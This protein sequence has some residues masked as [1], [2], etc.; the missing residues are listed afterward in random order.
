LNEGNHFLLVNP[1]Q[2]RLLIPAITN[3][4]R[5]TFADAMILLT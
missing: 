3:V 4:I 5:G 2:F 1:V